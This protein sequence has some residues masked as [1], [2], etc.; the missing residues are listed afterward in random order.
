[1]GWV[2]ANTSTRVETFVLELYKEEKISFCKDLAV[3]TLEWMLR[4]APFQSVVFPSESV[5]RALRP[6]TRLGLPSK[7]EKASANRLA[8]TPADDAKMISRFESCDVSHLVG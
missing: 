8:T 7:A 2:I 4:P 3:M 1:M 6:V 5:M